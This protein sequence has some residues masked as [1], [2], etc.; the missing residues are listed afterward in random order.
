[1]S[2]Y[3]LMLKRLAKTIILGGPRDVDVAKEV[4]RCARE[5]GRVSSTSPLLK[6]ELQNHGESISIVSSN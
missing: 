4:H 1:M 5:C 2:F 3:V 6:E